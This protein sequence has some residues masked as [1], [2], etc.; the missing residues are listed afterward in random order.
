[1]N[2][3]TGDSEKAG[4]KTGRF[5][6]QELAIVVSHYELGTIRD[7]QPLRRGKEQ[8]PKLVLWTEKGKFLL[9]KR[10]LGHDDPYRIAL[11]HDLQLYLLRQHFPIPRLIGTRHSNSSMLQTDTAIYE[12][13]EYIDGKTY[14]GAEPAT[15]NAGETLRFFHRALEQFTPAYQVPTRTY[16]NGAGVRNHIQA[17]PAGPAKSENT[18]D[19]DQNIRNLA[20]SLFRAYN[21]ASDAADNA[22]YSRNDPV[23]CHGDWH[24]GNLIFQNERVAA[25]IDCESVRFMPALGDV[26]LGCL[27]FALQAHHGLDPQQWPDSFNSQR[28]RWFLQGY[29]TSWTR[30]DLNII[31]ALMIEA[32]IA[33]SV[34]S[35]AATGMFANLRGAT[36]LQIIARKV[37]WLQNQAPKEITL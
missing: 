18:A 35:I 12:L 37:L 22:G 6:S 8:A 26:A 16:H 33:E 32:L 27:Q 36:F 19:A 30:D 24:P 2:N 10:P 1:M 29:Q 3:H 4:Q 9:K 11:A 5:H 28:I 20:D 7:I 15:K 34:T 14:S 31:I 17:I 13:F 23:I 21:L 25:V